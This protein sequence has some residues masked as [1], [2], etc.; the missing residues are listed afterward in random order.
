VTVLLPL[1]RV[2]ADPSVPADLRAWP[3]TLAPLRQVLREGL[4]LGAVTVLT[5]ENGV[6]KST[7]VEAIA[8]AWGLGAEGGTINVAHRSRARPSESD[9]SDHLRLVRGAG[10]SR[11]G[12]FLRAETMHGLFTDL[13]QLRVGSVL[14]E[15]SHGEAFLDVVLERSRVRGLWVLDE[16]ESALSV[17]GCLALI[18][19]LRDLVAEGSQ[20]VLSTHSPILAALPGAD[21]YELGDWGLRAST[22]E[23]LDLVRTWRG[24]LDS[25][26]RY[27]RHLG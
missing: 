18:G 7:L 13:E 26:E 3:A 24:F 2:E 10:T 23:D 21:L 16:P 27:L 25:P 6:G 8:V 15:R 22:W 11:K 1:R 19:L 9:L 12:F 17:A 20:V 4:D 5:G 14:H